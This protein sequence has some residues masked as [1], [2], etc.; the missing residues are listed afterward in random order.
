M[1]E[2]VQAV[3]L[4]KDTEDLKKMIKWKCSE[5]SKQK[6]DKEQASKGEGEK[7]DGGE[8]KGQGLICWLKPE[9]KP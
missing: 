1:G 9:I 3:L 6:S 5:E 2:N 4:S 7:R 8:T